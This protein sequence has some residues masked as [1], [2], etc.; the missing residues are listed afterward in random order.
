VPTFRLRP[1]FIA[2]RTFPCVSTFASRR[3]KKTIPNTEMTWSTAGQ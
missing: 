3:N 2:W 1:G